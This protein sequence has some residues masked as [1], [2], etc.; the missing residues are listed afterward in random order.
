M[1]CL[2]N[3]SVEFEFDSRFLAVMNRQSDRPRN[4]PKA[5][6]LYFF[7]NRKELCVH[8]NPGGL[9]E[10]VMFVCDSD[11]YLP[12]MSHFNQIAD[13]AYLSREIETQS[14]IVESPER[15]NG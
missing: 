4:A 6:A 2:K 14:E 9:K 12:G 1:V 3:G 5:P 11:I 8:P 15:D 7:S 10:M 13:C